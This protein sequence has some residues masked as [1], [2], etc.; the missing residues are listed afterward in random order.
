MDKGD[1]GF[2]GLARNDPFTNATTALLQT[3]KRALLESRKGCYF[4]IPE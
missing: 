2:M 1:R 4:K 3:Q